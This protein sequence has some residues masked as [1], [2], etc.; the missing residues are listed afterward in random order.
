MSIEVETTISGR[1]RGVLVELDRQSGISMRALKFFDLDDACLRE[2]RSCHFDP[3]T[4]ELL[5][6][7]RGYRLPDSGGPASPIN[8]ASYRWQKHCRG[9]HQTP[10]AA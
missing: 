4:S 9:L 1:V 7:M 10:I 6:R 2:Q 5:R 3:L 8:F